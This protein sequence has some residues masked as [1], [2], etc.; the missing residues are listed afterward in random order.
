METAIIILGIFEKIVEILG[1]FA[2]V[3]GVFL[4]L[5][6][7]AFL[8]IKA[9]EIKSHHVQI[10]DLRLKLGRYLGLGLDLLIASD[11]LKTIIDPSTKTLTLLAV[12]VV[13]RVMLTMF[14]S[15]EIEHIIK[16]EQRSK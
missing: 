15:K 13:I 5:V 11:I 9:K 2:I 16:L 10:E 12:I 8:L 1:G 7:Y 14:L 4:A 3:V 6:D